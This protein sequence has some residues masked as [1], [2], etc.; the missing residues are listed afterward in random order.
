MDNPQKPWSKVLTGI[1]IVLVLSTSS[2]AANI[3]PAKTLYVGKTIFLPNS[4]FSVSLILHDSNGIL[5]SGLA[6]PYP[7]VFLSFGSDDSQLVLVKYASSESFSNGILNA[8]FFG[9]TKSGRWTLQIFVLGDIW[10]VTNVT[11]STAQLSLQKSILYNKATVRAAVIGNLVLN[12]VDMYGNPTLLP[13]GL[14]NPEMTLVTYC[15]EP[16]VCGFVFPNF[17]FGPLNLVSNAMAEYVI[18]Y[19]TTRSG[20]YTIELTFQTLGWLPN[21]I[22]GNLSV[23]AQIPAANI[24]VLDD[25]PN[26]TI[27]GEPTNFSVQGRDVYGNDLTTFWTEDGQETNSLSICLSN[28]TQCGIVSRLSA[29]GP[30]YGL[31]L[32]A[33]IPVQLNHGSVTI[34]FTLTQAGLY[35]VDVWLP[36]LFSNGS[37][38]KTAIRGSPYSFTVKA[39]ESGLGTSVVF[40]P[41]CLNLS[42][43]AGQNLS[44]T[45]TE[46]DR[47]GNQR[48]VSR[49][50][51]QVVLIRG[52][53]FI[54]NFSV[55]ALD[56][57]IYRL[58]LMP[59]KSG[60][61]SIQCRYGRGVVVPSSPFSLQ[62]VPGELSAEGTLIVDMSDAIIGAVGSDN[63]F[64]I[65]SGD[66]FQ[67]H[68]FLG[69]LQKLISFN[70]TA[71]VNAR[72]PCSALNYSNY[73]ALSRVHDNGGGIYELSYSTTVGG[74]FSASIKVNGELIL[75]GGLAMPFG[76]LVDAGFPNATNSFAFT[77]GETGCVDIIAQNISLQNLLSC[78]IAGSDAGFKVRIEDGYGN[79]RIVQRS[80]TTVQF[81]VRLI[82]MLM[83][84]DS[85]AGLPLWN[86]NVVEIVKSGSGLQEGPAS[87]D[88]GTFDITFQATISGLYS[89]AVYLFDCEFAYACL[90]GTQI[91]NSPVLYLIKPGLPF[92]PFSSAMIDQQLSLATAGQLTSFSIFP[93]DQYQNRFLNVKTTLSLTIDWALEIDSDSCGPDSEN[94][95][96][97]P[98][99]T[100][101][102]SANGLIWAQYSMTLA[103]TYKLRIYA[104]TSQLKLAGSPFNITVLPSISS[105][106]SLIL[107]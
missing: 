104:T 6:V 62:V 2:S 98:T 8:S 76:V 60:N 46:Y 59:T 61:Y 90:N 100:L 43:A 48:T 10:A 16:G 64:E 14:L 94:F 42:I 106:R 40:S 77:N 20:M 69:G 105:L 31:N 89:I 33:P 72:I 63:S 52:I 88:P 27:A 67:N 80:F 95:V 25:L 44:I 73:Q 22:I 82:K 91:G 12:T 7:P 28:P 58:T 79:W 92:A 23:Q 53:S 65:E 66:K 34:S 47:Y 70:I 19:E 68:I 38:F 37:S 13:S 107:T 35:H 84:G 103:G 24:M 4:N 99:G 21:S 29:A 26:V 51:F 97:C 93:R 18:A 86:D 83:V 56:S 96:K 102:G 17:T 30:R 85:S 1:V 74:W 3:D 39:D 9:I 45:M 49:S 5:I 32:P 101:T 57:G 15:T 50:D 36:V 71:C 78:S 54:Q 75:V 81:S 11:I 87:V 55:S 41:S